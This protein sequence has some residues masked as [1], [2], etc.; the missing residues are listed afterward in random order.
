MELKNKQ[1]F[2]LSGFFF[3]SGICFSSW[4]SRIPNIKDSFGFIEAELGTILLTMPIC[5]LIGIPI[6]CSLVA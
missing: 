5:S 2:A 3:L 1:R 4:A 6:Y